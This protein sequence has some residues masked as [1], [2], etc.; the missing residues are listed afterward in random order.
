MDKMIFR[1]EE[2]VIWEKVFSPDC[3][4]DGE[5][6]GLHGPHNIGKTTL[7]SKLVNR[8][9]EE[10]KEGKH[11]FV[12]C[13][14]I[15]L[16]NVSTTW[17]SWFY[18]FEQMRYDI[19]PDVLENAPRI[20]G[21]RE[22]EMAQTLIKYFEMMQDLEKWSS[23]TDQQKEH[24]FN[25]VFRN[26]RAIGIRLIIVI[27]EFDEAKRM[28]TDGFYFNQL[29][30]LSQ[31]ALTK[32][33]HSIILVSRR[34]LLNI[35]HH[36]AGGS[37]LYDAYD[38]QGRAVTLSGFDDKQMEELFSLFPITLN[39]EQKKDIV[40]YCGRNPGL[41]RTMLDK[42]SQEETIQAIYKKNTNAFRAVYNETC[43]LMKDEKLDND[44][45][46]FDVYVE[47]FIGPITSNTHE[48]DMAFLESM[49]FVVKA[50]ENGRAYQM[51]DTAYEPLAPLF[52]N[53]ITESELTGDINRLSTLLI[54]TE[55]KFREAIH[56]FGSYVY[57]DQWEKELDERLAAINPQKTT[58]QNNFYQSYQRDCGE[59]GNINRAV[60]GTKL[61]VVSISD[62]YKLTKSFGAALEGL[63]R[64]LPTSP[65]ETT[66]NFFEFLTSCRNLD[67]HRNLRVLDTVHMDRLN[68]TCKTLL[69]RFQEVIPSILQQ[70]ADTILSQISKPEKTYSPISDWA[71]RGVNPLKF[72]G[73][74]V[75]LIEG[76][77]KIRGNISGFVEIEGNRYP[78]SIPKNDVFACPSCQRST[79][80]DGSY[81]FPVRLE[82]WDDNPQ[83]PHFEAKP[84]E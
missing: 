14:R 29:F 1:P 32:D 26:L 68:D 53:Y 60:T 75:T 55:I 63:L 10:K 72:V 34:S 7:V 41:L 48:N 66:D 65:G 20:K 39:D 23:F 8:F 54:Q 81:S 5:C 37:S 69:D 46:C 27:D 49:G 62:L 9:E 82:R 80:E 12:Y 79:S 38:G 40:F 43:K 83:G 73:Q 52:I 45:R 47:E 28:C 16:K 71:A 44:L 18:L 76:E 31:K 50:M 61:D 24:F 56:Q 13:Y 58:L 64:D 70:N 15:S 59:Y 2:E 6:L 57:K 33:N 35:E 11:P 3:N 21:A 17:E 36:M 74:T 19:T 22:K 78:C 25:V 30:G 42:F 4:T 84:I 51:T 67:G 77:K